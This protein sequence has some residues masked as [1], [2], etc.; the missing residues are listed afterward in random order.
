MLQC[1]A[2]KSAWIERLVACGL[3][4]GAGALIGSC[5]LS[6]PAPMTV[7]EGAYDIVVL[8]PLSS[9][10]SARHPAV[11]DQRVMETI[12]HGIYIQ[13]D[14]R[15]LQRLLTGRT[16]PSP[17]FSDEQSA[18]V[19][20]FLV[21]ALAQ[22][23]SQQQVRFRLS[24]PHS[25]GDETTQGVLYC[26][27]PFVY[28]TLQQFSDGQRHTPI[29]K[30][31]RQLPDR[32]GLGSRRLIFQLP[33]YSGSRVENSS[34]TTLIINYVHLQQWLATHD[35]ADAATVGRLS[36]PPSTAAGKSEPEEK[37]RA[38]AVRHTPSLNE[39]IVRKDLE[40]ESLKEEI[41]ALR[42]AL[43][44]QQRDVNRLKRRPDTTPQ[45]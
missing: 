7:H 24:H 36:L 6:Q 5:S 11:I 25:Q 27:E 3:V 43:E 26:A 41:R 45:P 33:A 40:I 9:E 15:L 23:T 42:H 16:P 19:S 21:A 37:D 28:F 38:P 2:M 18:T 22:A 1:G 10:T 34:P 17:V 12:L 31:G 32:T 20:R 14:E 35:A 30:P 39:L 4:L 44:V 29:E 8:E 13:E